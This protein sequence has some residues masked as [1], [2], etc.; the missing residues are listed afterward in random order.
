MTF[1]S[2]DFAR[3]EWFKK[4]CDAGF[5][6]SL[7]S[8]FLWEGVTYYLTESQVEE[9]FL[10]MASCQH[11]I[12]AYAVYYKWFSLDP[13]TIALMSRGFGEPF[14]SGVNLGN[15]AG[16]TL[17]VG[18]ETLDIVRSDEA[19]R[20]YV[21]LNL[22]GRLVCPA[23]GGFAMVIAGTNPQRPVRLPS[24]VSVYPTDPVVTWDPAREDKRQAILDGLGVAL[25]S[26]TALLQIVSS[27]VG[28]DADADQPLMEAGIDSGL[29][30]ELTEILQGEVG[31]T[32]ELPSTLTFDHPSARAL[33]SFLCQEMGAEELENSQP[34]GHPR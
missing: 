32:V 10:S 8:L 1:V 23:F 34:N 26:L 30:V 5:D 28:D 13:R 7:P 19:N 24:A 21:P 15:E 4:L 2:V 11:A 22:A 27:L 25:P 9:T 3:E 6:N 29:S 12:V 14:Q 31:D 16:P 18:M 33:G 17:A 20:R